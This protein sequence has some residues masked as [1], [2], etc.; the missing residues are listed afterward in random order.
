MEELSATLLV[1]EN[2][3]IQMQ[4]RQSWKEKSREGKTRLTLVEIGRSLLFGRI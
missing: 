1:E 3:V 2:K 4:I